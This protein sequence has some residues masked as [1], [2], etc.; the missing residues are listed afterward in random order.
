VRT[1]RPRSSE[2]RD[3]LEGGDQASLEMHLKAMMVR[4]W[5]PYI[6]KIYFCHQEPLGVC[7]SCRTRILRWSN[8][9]VEWTH[10]VAFRCTWERWRQICEDIGGL[11]AIWGAPSPGKM[12]MR[13]AQL[14]EKLFLGR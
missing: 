12:T 9:E 1:W 11:V 8:L 10:A 3:A 6:R 2:L 7:G 13:D 5:R 14:I 4:T